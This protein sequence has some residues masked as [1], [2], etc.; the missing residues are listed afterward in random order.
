MVYGICGG[1]LIVALKLTEY[2]FL[3]LEHS[4]EIYG[5]LIAALFAGAR[6]CSTRPG[7]PSSK[8]RPANSRSSGSSAPASSPEWV[9]FRA[10]PEITRKD[11]DSRGRDR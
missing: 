9:I 8:S 10:M 1:L 3:V 6:S 7:W 11:D 4:V 2:R 5:A